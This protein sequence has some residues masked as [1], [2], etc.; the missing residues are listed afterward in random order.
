MKVTLKK[1]RRVKMAQKVKNLY[2]MQETQVQSLGREDP[3]EKGMATHSSV[4]A[5]R[6]PWIKELGVAG[7]RSKRKREETRKREERSQGGR[8]QMERE[9]KRKKLLSNLIRAPKCSH[10]L[11]GHGSLSCMS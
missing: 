5:W 4:L 7:M 11:F 3:L 1:K 10:V 6:I 8:K 9:I 2:A